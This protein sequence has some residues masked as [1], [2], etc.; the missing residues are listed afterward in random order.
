MY[1]VKDRG[2]VYTCYN[3]LYAD[4]DHPQHF[5]LIG[6]KMKAD[7]DIEFFLKL[8]S[9]VLIRWP[10]HLHRSTFYCAGTNSAV[11]P[12]IAAWENYSAGRRKGKKRART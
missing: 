10:I 4:L 9:L 1:K 11:M 3:K 2:S 7:P 8:E 6:N 5:L 12:E